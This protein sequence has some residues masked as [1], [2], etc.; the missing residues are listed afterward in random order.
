M[1]GTVAGF[2]GQDATVNPTAN[3]NVAIGFSVAEKIYNGKETVTQWIKCTVF[4]QAGKDAISQYLK[5]GTIVACTGECIINTYQKQT[6][7]TVSQIQMTVNNLQLLGG[8]KN[9]NSEPAASDYKNSFAKEKFAQYPQTPQ[10]V[11]EKATQRG[12][13]EEGAIVNDLPF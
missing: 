12:P 9:E 1:Q 5:K 10:Q 2:I 7:E 4:K 3:G 11:Y 13:V 6:G 8:N